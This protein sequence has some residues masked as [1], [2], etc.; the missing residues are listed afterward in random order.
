MS[1][2]FFTSMALCI[3][4]TILYQLFQ[5]LTPANANPAVALT[6]TYVSSL[7][8]CLL[9]LPVIFPLKK[10]LGS[11]IHQLNFASFALALALVGLEVGFLLLYRSGWRISIAAV[12]VN[13]TATVLLLI[14]GVVFFREKITLVNAIGILVCIAGLVLINWKS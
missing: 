9:T 11:E 4:A 10:D 1:V 5:K 2:M 13:V 7:A 14:I 12:V 8:L 6:A 3:L